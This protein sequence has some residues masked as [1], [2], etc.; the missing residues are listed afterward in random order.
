MVS[1]NII[2]KGLNKDVTEYKT[3][4]KMNMKLVYPDADDYNIRNAKTHTIVYE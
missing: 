4:I 1:I 3:N 2:G